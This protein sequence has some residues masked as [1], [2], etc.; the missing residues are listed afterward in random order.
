MSSRWEIPS[1]Q[2]KHID[3]SDGVAYDYASFEEFY[4]SVHAPE[5]W[6]KAGEMMNDEAWELIAKE[7]EI[8]L[9]EDARQQCLELVDNTLPTS[10]NLTQDE[11]GWGGAWKYD[12]LQVA[13]SFWDSLKFDKVK[14][15]R[16]SV[17]PTSTYNVAASVSYPGFTLLEEV[18]FATQ[19][20]DGHDII[21]PKKIFSEMLVHWFEGHKD[22]RGISVNDWRNFGFWGSS[23]FEDIKDSPVFSELQNIFLDMQE[24]IKLNGKS[25]FI[26][27]GTPIKVNAHVHW[28]IINKLFEGYKAELQKKYSFNPHACEFVPGENL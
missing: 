24:E 5:L 27:K 25:K 28:P 11:D 17:S 3:P 22:F 4:G 26:S 10:V 20:M 8:R 1:S 14:A 19:L 15:S 6:I 21:S 18:K 12:F 9:K 2:E 16:V 7:E 23:K 13:N